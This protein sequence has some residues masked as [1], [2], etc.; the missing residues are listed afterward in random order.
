MFT[1][2]LCLIIKIVQKLLTMT[3]IVVLLYHVMSG[4]DTIK[5][6]Q[7]GYRETSHSIYHPISL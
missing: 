4:P 1:K 7:L 2:S 3:G 5:S 6:T